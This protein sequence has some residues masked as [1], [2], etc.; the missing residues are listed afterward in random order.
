MEFYVRHA[1]YGLTVIHVT[2]NPTG[3]VV[4]AIAILGTT[5]HLILSALPVPLFAKY[6][7][8]IVH[9]LLAMMHL[10]LPT[11]EA[12]AHATKHTSNPQTL[13]VQHVDHFAK[14]VHLKRYAI[15]AMTK[16]IL[17]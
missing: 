17:P 7:H 11:Y 6:A 16:H 8:L 4:D 2:L 15:P 1:P 14:Y 9:A 10:I 13:S 12:Y 5:N 3:L